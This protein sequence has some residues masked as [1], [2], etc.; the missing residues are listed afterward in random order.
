MTFRNIDSIWPFVL[1]NITVDLYNNTPSI[2]YSECI[3]DISTVFETVC[4]NWCWKYFFHLSF[5]VRLN[6]CHLLNSS[7]IILS[8]HSEQAI[9]V[10]CQ[11]INMSSKLPPQG[12]ALAI[13]LECNR[14]S[15]D[16]SMTCSHISFKLLFKCH[17]FH[18]AFSR[19]PI[20]LLHLIILFFLP[21]LFSY[22]ASTT[23]KIILL[24]YV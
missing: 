14:L 17:L 22:F 16:I 7:T 3:F 11:F 24:I 10:A 2:Q 18:K 8:F 1:V 9:V 21:T 4:H 20:F 5:K 12:F 6:S 15:L 23:L 13:F 19:C